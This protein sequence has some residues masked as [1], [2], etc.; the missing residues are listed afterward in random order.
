MP[1]FY[2]YLPGVPGADLY[3]QAANSYLGNRFLFATSFPS[4]PLKLAVEYFT[5]LPFKPEV[6]EKALYK[7]ADWILEERHK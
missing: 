6:L 5:R 1:D 2:V 4:I 7:N 3:V